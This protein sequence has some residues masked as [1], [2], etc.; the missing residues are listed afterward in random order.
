[1]QTD[2]DF[3]EIGVSQ[4]PGGFFGDALA[5]QFA[6]ITELVIRIAL[7][8]HGQQFGKVFPLIERWVEQKHFRGPVFDCVTQIRSNAIEFE[9]VLFVVAFWVIA[10]F[11]F[12]DAAARRFEQHHPFV[13]GIQIPRQIGRAENI[14]VRQRFAVRRFPRRVEPRAAGGRNVKAGNRA[15]EQGQ[16]APRRRPLVADQMFQ[17]CDERLFALADHRVIVIRR[18]Q[19]PRII[20]R[21]FRPAEDDLQ[22][23]P[24][25]FQALADPQRSFDVPNVTGEADQPRFT[26]A[27]AWTRARSPSA[28]AS[29]AGKMSIS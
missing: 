20:R 8:Q 5:A 15:A 9:I 23:G 29:A 16:G 2:F 12:E 1:M 19:H 18:F 11:A 27:I 3:G 7:G 17:Q 26:L 28:L 21:D 25:S 24:Q 22:I 14:D 4:Q 13:G 10:E 6:E